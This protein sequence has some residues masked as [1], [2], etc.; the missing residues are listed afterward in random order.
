MLE[1]S[2]LFLKTSANH[3]RCAIPTMPIV[4]VFI[5][6]S[7]RLRPL[8]DPRG[9]GV[10]ASQTRLDGSQPDSCRRPCRVVSSLYP[11]QHP[12]DTI[13][14]PRRDVRN[15][16]SDSFVVDPARRVHRF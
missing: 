2:A 13:S 4:P 7:M 14:F 8:V 1:T 5:A 9:T 15:I 11:T 12:S 16:V 10:V 6:G 3:W